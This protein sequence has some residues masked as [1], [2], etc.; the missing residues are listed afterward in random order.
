[1][2]HF[3]M[4]HPFPNESVSKVIG[5]TLSESDPMCDEVLLQA[6]GDKHDKN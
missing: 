6:F 3:F 5:H 4:E 2:R 1:M